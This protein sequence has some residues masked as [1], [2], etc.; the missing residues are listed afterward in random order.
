MA[1]YDAAGMGAIVHAMGDCG[2]PWGLG[3]GAE[4]FVADALF[5]MVYGGY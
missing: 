1:L 2:C 3:R 5:C 4:F